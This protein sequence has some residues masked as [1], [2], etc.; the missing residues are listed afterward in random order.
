M[1]CA[2]ADLWNLLSRPFG[3]K[4]SRRAIS[5]WKA[6]VEVALSDFRNLLGSGFLC[7]LGWSN[8]DGKVAPVRSEVVH[9]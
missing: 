2:L 3:P 4:W 5:G 7:G 1:E 8:V 6:S 9:M